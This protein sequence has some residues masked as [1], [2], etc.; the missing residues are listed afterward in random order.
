MKKNEAY[1]QKENPGV[2]YLIKQKVIN[3][4]GDVYLIFES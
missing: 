3:K 2:P 4:K 1:P